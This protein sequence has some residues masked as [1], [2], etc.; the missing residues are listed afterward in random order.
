MGRSAL[1]VDVGSVRLVV[2][3]M[4]IG[5]ESIENGLRNRGSGAVR[6][7]EG[8]LLSLEAAGSQ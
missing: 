6:A 4:G 2:D 3:Y 1:V 5:T 7:V 8:D